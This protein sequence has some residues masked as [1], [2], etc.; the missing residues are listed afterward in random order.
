MTILQLSVCKV[1]LLINKI[2]YDFKICL[3]FLEGLGGCFSQVLGSFE[4]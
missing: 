3:Q 1:M 2:Y 4:K